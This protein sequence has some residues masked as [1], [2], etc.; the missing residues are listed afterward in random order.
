MEKLG[1]LKEGPPKKLE[2]VLEMLLH[3]KNDYKDKI[4]DNIVI[5]DTEAVTHKCQKNWFQGIIDYIEIIQ[6][7]LEFRGQITPKEIDEFIKKFTSQ[8]FHD[9]ALVTESDINEANKILALGILIVNR[10]LEG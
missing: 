9:Q 6:E 3:L 1:S 8:R 10:L 4:P 5:D 2:R 7:H